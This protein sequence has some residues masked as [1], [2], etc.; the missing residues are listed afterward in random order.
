M[1]LTLS[2]RHA[3]MEI[4]GSYMSDKHTIGG[5]AVLINLAVLA[6]VAMTLR[7]HSQIRTLQIRY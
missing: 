7:R 6:I 5:E 2:R 3:A 1:G 4:F